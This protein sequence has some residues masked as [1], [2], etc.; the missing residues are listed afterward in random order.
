MTVTAWARP[1]VTVCQWPSIS[2]WQCFTESQ[3]HSLSAMIIMMSPGTQRPQCHPVTVRSG[4]SRTVTESPAPSRSLN[5]A[6]IMIPM[7]TA[8]PRPD[9]A[10]VL[11]WQ[12]I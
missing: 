8:P 4:P 10:A 7:R 6:A 9:W 5:L 2:A 12:S 11:L 3:R 1:G